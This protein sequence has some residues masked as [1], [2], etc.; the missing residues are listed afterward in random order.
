MSFLK[1]SSIG[2]CEC[3]EYWE[4]IMKIVCLARL[5]YIS[6]LRSNTG[7]T[8]VSTPILA[9]FVVLRTKVET[10]QIKKYLHIIAER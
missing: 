3:S 7:N 6:Q 8:L 5:F 4:K 2:D 1:P 10:Q 9:M